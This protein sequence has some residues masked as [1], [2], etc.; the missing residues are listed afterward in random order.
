MHGAIRHQEKQQKP[1]SR[2]IK[3]NMKTDYDSL[4]VRP[5]STDSY[6]G[7]YHPKKQTNSPNGRQFHN[8]SLIYLL[9]IRYL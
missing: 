8:H 3:T 2:Q 1:L 7:K 6:N 5:N 4:Y 9:I